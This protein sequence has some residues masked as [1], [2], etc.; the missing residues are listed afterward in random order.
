PV[1]K[2]QHVGAEVA[3]QQGS[4]CLL[5][6]VLLLEAFDFEGQFGVGADF[7][8]AEFTDLGES[9]S[10]PSAIGI[11]EGSGIGVGVWDVKHGAVSGNETPAAVEGTGSGELGQGAC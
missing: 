6:G 10:A 5:R 8:Q 3:K 11:T 9:A 4:H 1:P 2:E 7:Y